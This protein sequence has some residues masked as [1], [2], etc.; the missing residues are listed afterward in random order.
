MCYVVYR[1]GYVL[2]SAECLC[3]F[4][5]LIRDYVLTLNKTRRRTTTLTKQQQ[6][7]AKTLA[8]NCAYHWI[9]NKNN[10]KKGI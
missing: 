5:L 10:R 6:N 3:A 1:F 9:K 7:V 2:A 4:V 8:V